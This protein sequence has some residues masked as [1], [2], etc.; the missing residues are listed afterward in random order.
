MR[1]FFKLALL[2]VIGYVLYQSSDRVRDIVERVRNVFWEF[3]V[4]LELNSI[5]QNLRPGLASG[6][7]PPG[8][9]R[10]YLRENLASDEEDPS[11]DAWD[12]PY[13]L[14]REGN[15]ILVASC[16]PDTECETEDDIVTPV[17]T[18]RKKS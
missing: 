13:Q 16:G 5:A 14:R 12:T 8:D 3:K 17:V 1:F 9:L 6:G 18:P 15:L 10:E 4:S 2:A 7:S 11:L